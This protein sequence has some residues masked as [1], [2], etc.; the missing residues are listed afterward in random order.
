MVAGTAHLVLPD[1]GVVVLTG[2]NGAGKSRFAEA[3]ACANW[4]ETLRGTTPWRKGEA[5]SV[6]VVSDRGKVKRFV[7][8][9]GTQKLLVDDGKADTPTKTQEALSSK[10]GDFKLWR[11][12][13]VFSSSDA[14]HFTSAKDAERKRLIES[15]L[16]LGVF[17]EAQQR[18][19][20]AIKAKQDELNRADLEI[21]E[22]EKK[23]Y[24]N[25]AVLDNW[26]DAQE[27]TPPPQPT[28]P[29]FPEPTD[30]ELD[31]VEEEIEVIEGKIQTLRSGM[32]VPDV[33]T[34]ASLL[35]VEV[36][37]AAA[38]CRSAEASYDL[39]KSGKCSKCERPFEG[40][41][42]EE[43]LGRL[44]AARQ[45]HTEKKNEL[46]EQNRLA[47]VKRSE[48]V[49]Q[50]SELGNQDRA[51]RAEAARL[52][53]LVAAWSNHEMVMFNWT[54]NWERVKADHARVVATQQRNKAKINAA[55][56]EWDEQRGEMLELVKGLQLELL[57]LETAAKILGIRGLR[58]YVLGRALEGIE[59]VAN[60]WLNRVA[61]GVAIKLDDHTLNKT[62]G[63]RDELSLEIH[64]FGGGEGYKATSGGERRRVDAAIL[65]A[66]AEI[67][68]AQ[69]GQT[70]GTLWFDEVFDALDEEGRAAI[71][72][73]L[74]ELGQTRSVVVITHM[75]D[76][77]QR[78]P[79]VARYRVEGG[80]LRPG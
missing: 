27:P 54:Q 68:S 64:G 72:E 63:V 69:S 67:A 71:A 8:P 51:K 22:I 28:P 10:V 49:Q 31:K 32:A 52:H 46:D 50:L 6:E 43:S 40:E 47:W 25:K 55:I 13:H 60:G 20:D 15:L 16:G 24:A 78:I 36:I 17:D 30:E 35:E 57:E 56:A 33:S 37:N 18:C 4:D 34:K 38:E 61:F 14:A 73:A 19:N 9:K 44:A 41:T 23:R 26:V 79:A 53:N 1:A 11:N 80:E 5:G 2:P 74:G 58:T 65:L 48:S 59:V 66:L 42:I 62:G 3:V 12:T 70:D 21:R 29:A 76:L 75:E 39:V 7:T 45:M 77:A